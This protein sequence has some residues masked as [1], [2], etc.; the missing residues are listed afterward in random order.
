M[1]NIYEE[2][3]LN[4]WIWIF[5]LYRGGQFYWWR[6][7]EDPA[8]TTDLS[9]QITDKIYHILLY[10]SLFIRYIWDRIKLSASTNGPKIFSLSYRMKW[11]IRV[12]VCQWFAVISQW[13]SPGPPVS[14]TNKTDRHDIIEIFISRNW[15]YFKLDF[16]YVTAVLSLMDRLLDLS[17]NSL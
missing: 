7:P 13:F 11:L 8:K 9:Q 6:K 14:S 12:P 2:S 15:G 1:M 3:T 10:T 5:Q 17:K 4:F 16:D